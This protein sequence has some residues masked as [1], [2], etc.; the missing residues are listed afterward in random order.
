M[1]QAITIR[2]DGTMT[3]GDKIMCARI[4]GT[5]P[6]EL[7]WRDADLRVDVTH[8]WHDRALPAIVQAI[9]DGGDLPD[10]FHYRTRRDGVRMVGVSR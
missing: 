7:V 6:R 9:I 3:H 2:A 4:V 1:A 10:G 8:A 5:S